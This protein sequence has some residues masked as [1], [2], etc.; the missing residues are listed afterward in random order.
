MGGAW[1]LAAS[2]SPRLC[3][4]NRPAPPPAPA[5]AIYLITMVLTLV[6]ALVFHSMLLCMLFIVI[7]F[8]AL[9]WY[10]ASYIPF[11]QQ[12][13][14]KLVGRGGEAGDAAVTW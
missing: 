12:M 11:A 9:V 5:A 4:L 7:Q 6:S 8:A 2:P 3:W 10:C 1:L 14:L 13:L